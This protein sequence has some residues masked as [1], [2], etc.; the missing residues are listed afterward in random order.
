MPAAATTSRAT[1]LDGLARVRRKAIECSA[2]LSQVR[3]DPRP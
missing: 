3:G 1:L 2:F